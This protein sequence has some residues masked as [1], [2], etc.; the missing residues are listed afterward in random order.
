MSLLGSYLVLKVEGAVIGETTSVSLKMTATG[1][2]RTSQDSGLR[3]SYSAGK[4]KVGMAGAFLFASGGNWETLYSYLKTG[5][6]M[7][8]S[9]FVNGAE[10]LS[11]FGIMKKLS[12]KG[13]DEA[14]L[15]TGAYGI[16]YNTTTT[17]E[18][19]D[20][21]LTETGIEITTETGVTITTE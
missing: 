14:S 16:R 6:E 1:L 19:V 11:G 5:A 18:E 7:G 21:I 4:V 8:I 9:L 2:D 13:A 3:S 15:V 12:L 17:Q 10:I 20:A